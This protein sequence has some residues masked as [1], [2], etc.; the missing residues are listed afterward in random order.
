VIEMRMRQKNQVDPRQLT[1]GERGRGKSF[2]TDSEKKR[3]PNSYA[4]EKDRIGENVDAEKINEH[5]G[6]TKP[7]GRNVRIAPFCGVRFCKRRRNGTQTLYGPFAPE[8][9]NPTAHTRA[10]ETWLFWLFLHSS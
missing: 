7:C 10:A 3:D 6:V 5:R 1:D 9:M 2:R 4:R 8:M